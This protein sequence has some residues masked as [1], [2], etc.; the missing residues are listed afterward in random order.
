MSVAQLIDHVRAKGVRLRV[1]GDRL[2]YVAPSG[3]LTEELKL[4]LKAQKMEIIKTLA[5]GTPLPADLE[6]R[7]RAMCARWRYPPDEVIDGLNAA[8][9]DPAKAWLAVL[10]DERRTD[11]D[12]THWLGE[13]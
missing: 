9:Q 4:A 2:K 7:Y 3:A 12:R 5:M 10:A 1:A 8:R 6:Q 11:E 13:G